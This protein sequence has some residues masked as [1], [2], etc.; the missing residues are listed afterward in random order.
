[1]LHK[2]IENY[3][4]IINFIYYTSN[5]GIQCTLVVE[6]KPCLVRC[7]S[8]IASLVTGNMSYDAYDLTRF[9]TRIRSNLG[10]IGMFLWRIV[11]LRANFWDHYGIHERKKTKW[12]IEV[13]SDRWVE[14]KGETWTNI[15][16]G[17]WQQSLARGMTE[18]SSFKEWVHHVTH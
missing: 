11:D 2:K 15:P 7:P 10:H 13:E 4:C 18:P 17:V 6:V 5:T 3:C 12:G 8:S 16:A 9:R 14:M 1:M